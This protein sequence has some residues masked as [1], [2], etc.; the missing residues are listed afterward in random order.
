[1]FFWMSRSCLGS[2][3]RQEFVGAS[4]RVRSREANRRRPNQ[5]HRTAGIELCLAGPSQGKWRT[6]PSRLRL[7]RRPSY[8]DSRECVCRVD[9]AQTNSRLPCRRNHSRP[10]AYSLGT[11][12]HLQFGRSHRK[13]A[14][15]ETT[16]NRPS[17]V[18]STPAEWQ[19]NLTMRRRTWPG[20]SST[21]PRRLGTGERSRIAQTC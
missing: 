17:A 14:E 15:F 5:G 21:P 7:R 1:M 2:M 19:S 16:F 18:K 4:W 10:Q 6:A 13:I 11:P 3:E 9:L 8:H 20:R 12:T